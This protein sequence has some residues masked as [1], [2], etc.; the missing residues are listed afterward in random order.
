MVFLRH[1]DRMGT[2]V[3]FFS[4]C[5]PSW[6]RNITLIRVY[7]RLYVAVSHGNAEAIGD[8]S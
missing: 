8:A 6:I 5:V 4:F 7:A 2:Q 1:R 3:L